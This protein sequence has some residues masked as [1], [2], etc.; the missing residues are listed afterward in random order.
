MDVSVILVSYNTKDLTRDCLNSIYEKTKDI[1]FEI[2]VVDNNSH[3]GSA[4]MVEKM[5]PQVK[6]I[7]NPENN[8]FGAA[9]NIA[10]RQSN[11]KYVFCLNTDTILVNN[12]IK[13]LFDYM[14]ANLNV[15]ACGGQMFDK[16][17]IPNNSGGHFP[18]VQRIFFQFLGLNRIFKNYWNN[19]LAPTTINNYTEPTEVDYIIGADLMIRRSI[20]NKVGLYDE[21][22]FL[23]GEESDLCFRIKKNGNNVVF[24]PDSKIIHFQGKSTQNINTL[25]ISYESLIYWYKKNNSLFSCILLQILMC[26][27][28]LFC[29]IFTRNEKFY[30]LFI[31][32]VKKLFT[33]SF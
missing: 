9:N 4:E 23:Y 24:V 21:N 27:N 14:E 29:F 8:G 30:K 28:F 2:F 15:G 12:A 11:A 3:D 32:F 5:F 7:K 20:L 10:V 33:N 25:K 13:I 18:T 16:D 6:L 19:K 1:E 22:I 17:M 31:T 26:T